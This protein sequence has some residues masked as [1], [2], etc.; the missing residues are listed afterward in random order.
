M[1]APKPGS[2]GNSLQAYMVG[3]ERA[4][5]SRPSKQMVARRLLA[6][7]G[8]TD[9]EVEAEGRRNAFKYFDRSSRPVLKA[10]PGK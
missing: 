3:R 4:D 8:F 7:A 1:P 2:G 9:I 10:K 6:E 5:K